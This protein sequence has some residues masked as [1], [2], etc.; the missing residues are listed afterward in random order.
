MKLIQTDRLILEPLR[1]NHSDIFYEL[2]QD[3]KIYKFIDRDVPISREWLSEQFAILASL[4]LER[5]KADLWDWAVYCPKENSYIGMAEYTLYDDGHCNVA[6]VFFSKFWNKGY[7]YEAMKA[8][9]DYIQRIR[10][11][12]IFKIDCDSENM[13]SI[14]MAKKLNFT[15]VKTVLNAALLHGQPSNELYFEFKN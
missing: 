9:M 4:R 10:P 14:A 3:T 7:A 2:Y 8:S 11:N 1:E 6:Y 13:A 15:Y 5:I 12:T